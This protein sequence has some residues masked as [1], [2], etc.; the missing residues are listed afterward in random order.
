MKVM[1]AFH[2]LGRMAS[3]NAYNFN[4]RGFNNSQWWEGVHQNLAGGGEPN[5]DDPGG[6]SVRRFVIIR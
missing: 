1:W 6:T 2:L 5:I 4:D 3:G